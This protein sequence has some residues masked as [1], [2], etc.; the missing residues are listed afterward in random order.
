MPQH[1]N[2]AGK[3]TYWLPLIG[4]VLGMASAHAAAPY[5]VTNGHDL[6]KGS[7]REALGSGAS[8][9]IIDSS[10]SVINIESTL[11]YN[12]TAPLVIKGSGQTIDGG[13]NGNTLLAVTSGADLA[14]SNL[15]FTD[16]AFYG[17]RWQGGGEGILIEVPLTRTGI[18][19]LKLT[20]VKVTGVGD[21]GVHVLDCNLA[22]CGSG[23]GGAGDGSPASI[24]VELKNVRISRVGYGYFDADGL[25]VDE[26]G[27]GS[28][29]LRAVR[30]RFNNVGADG[31]ELDE[32][33]AGDV[34]LALNK[35]RFTR[36]GA[37]CDGL[38][39]ELPGDADSPLADPRDTGCY[40]DGEID[41]DDGFDVDEAGEGS[42]VGRISN[43]LVSGNFDEG[44]DF[45]EEGDG[46]FDLDLANI[47][48]Y[49]NF[50]EGIK[51]SA[52]DRGDLVARLSRVL[53]TD[54]D[55][56]GVQIELD[57]N[58]IVDVA[59]VASVISENAKK[60][61]K[62]EQSQDAPKGML[63]VRRSRIAVIDTDNVNEI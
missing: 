18:V 12:G 32:G 62:V 24:E 9:I 48:A 23:G 56:D 45:D 54:S 16:G 55:D 40:D 60:D 2:P 3:L 61:L 49:R 44:L 58:G 1:R 63:K 22:N 21:H 6:G 29:T 28:I 4:L 36:N 50:D 25:R 51:L 8:K 30:S 11:T 33:G 41:L 39:E 19:Q 35:V 31:V 57:G 13:G 15:T 53:V 37:Y 10:V 34:V 43:A 27:D 26:R 17:Q 52:E 46:G 5:M 42:I 20:G 47:R 38:P 14:V 7:L 59:V